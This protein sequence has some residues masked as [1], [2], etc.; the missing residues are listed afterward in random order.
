MRN[1]EHG[2]AMRNRM[3]ERVECR[4]D[5]IIVRRGLIDSRLVM[6]SDLEFE[7]RYCTYLNT[8]GQATSSS[9]HD[10]GYLSPGTFHLRLED[11]QRRRRETFDV[12][13]QRST[14]VREAMSMSLQ[15]SE[16]NRIQARN[17]LLQCQHAYTAKCDL[18]DLGMLHRSFIAKKQLE[19]R[20][21][22]IIN[23]SRVQRAQGED[24][25][26]IAVSTSI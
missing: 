15:I 3:H 8:D 24:F 26:T 17:D 6:S 25:L 16:I 4:V 13:S 19:P 10:F 21:V 9:R 5:E 12:L 18:N 11:R 1:F 7:R 2:S 14:E 20:Q 22:G 23:L